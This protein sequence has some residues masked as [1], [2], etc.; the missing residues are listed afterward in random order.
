MILKQVVRIPE[1]SPNE[2]INHIKL[3]PTSNIPRSAKPNAQP[4]RRLKLQ[5]L[6]PLSINKISTVTM[7]KEE[8]I[9]I[10][11][12]GIINETMTTTIRGILMAIA[13]MEVK[14]T[15]ITKDSEIEVAAATETDNVVDTIEIAHKEVVA[16]TATEMGEMAETAEMAETGIIMN[17]TEGIRDIKVDEMVDAT[18]IVQSKISSTKKQ[19]ILTLTIDSSTATTP[20]S[21]RKSLARKKVPSSSRS[22]SSQEILPRKN[23][24]NELKNQARTNLSRWM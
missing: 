8:N 13:K 15:V 12:E 20:I 6:K 7:A 19:S 2:T 17:A 11:V 10:D 5:S 16:M 23:T 14:D 18:S 21:S 9:M 4:S 22:I 24:M 1:T 3:N